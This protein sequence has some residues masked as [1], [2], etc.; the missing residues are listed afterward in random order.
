MNRLL[1]EAYADM[2]KVLI[3]SGAFSP[4]GSSA[5]TTPALNAS[6]AIAGYPGTAAANKGWGPAGFGKFV[7]SVSRTGTGVYSVVLTDCGTSFMGGEAWLL[8]DDATKTYWAQGSGIFTLS[9]KTW[10]VRT[11]QSSGAVPGA[12][13]VDIPNTSSPVIAFC[14]LF[15]L[16]DVGVE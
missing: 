9:T 13:V 14:L 12:A 2:P 4:A 3:V 11:L 7:Q 10:T 8:T 15:D 5:P 16:S 6:A 1:R